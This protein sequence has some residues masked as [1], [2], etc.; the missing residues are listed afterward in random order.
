MTQYASIS[1]LYLQ[2]F[3]EE[4]R[5]DLAD[6][7]LDAALSAASTLVDGHL[8][9]RFGAPLTSWT[10]EIVQW[11]C[12]VATFQ[13]MTGPRGLSSETPDYTVLRDRYEDAIKM[14]S[15]VQRQD[16]TPVGLVAVAPPGTSTLQPF[17][18]SSSVIDANGRRASSR[19]W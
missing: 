19:G 9:Q 11:V 2:G 8:G 4:A 17:V 15:R 12:A 16:Y 1:D 3:R 13:I 5:G 10:P 6:S 14:L 7:V 18:I